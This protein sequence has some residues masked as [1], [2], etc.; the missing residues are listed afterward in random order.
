MSDINLIR[1]DTESIQVRFKRR[2]REVVPN[3]IDEGDTFTLTF[4]DRKDK[5][6]LEKTI[7]YP[8]LMFY[9]SSKDTAKLNTSPYTY[10]VEF[11]KPNP[12]YDGTDDT[13]KYLFTKTLVI[14]KVNVLQDVTRRS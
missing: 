9:L 5:I 3:G 11:N 7:T 2:G 1:E 4:R 8:Y 13:D 10:D 12:D 14:G 6:V